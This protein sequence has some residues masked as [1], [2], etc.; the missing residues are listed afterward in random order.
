MNSHALLACCLLGALA[1]PASAGED[2]GLQFHDDYYA[3]FA[4]GV[5]YGLLL[6]GED[7]E[8][9]WCM[10]SELGYEAKSLGSGEEFQQRIEG[11]LSHCRAQSLQRSGPEPNSDTET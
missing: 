2:D 7:Y 9:A 3:G 6:R 1:G 4:Q 10:K 11:L 5:Y 8:V